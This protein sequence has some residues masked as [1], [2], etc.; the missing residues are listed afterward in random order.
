MLKETAMHQPAQH[1]R[2]PRDP[3]APV[4]E[5]DFLHG[6]WLLYGM[7]DANPERLRL[8]MLDTLHEAFPFHPALPERILLR[9]GALARVWKHPLMRAW[10]SAPANAAFDDV[11]LRIAATHPL[12]ADGWFNPENFFAE[13]LRWMRAEGAA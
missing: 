2:R 10:K 3:H 11:V 6:H 12:C 8:M 9:L 7:T 13:M 1:H 5:R 4:P